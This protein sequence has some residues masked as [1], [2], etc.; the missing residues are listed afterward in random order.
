MIKNLMTLSPADVSFY[1]SNEYEIKK[2]KI[3]RIDDGR[4]NLV[5]IAKIV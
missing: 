3:L 2:K 4:I 1:N 5:L